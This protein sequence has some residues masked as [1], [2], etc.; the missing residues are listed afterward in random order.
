MRALIAERNPTVVV[1]NESKST[2]TSSLRG[3]WPGA[4]L[5]EIPAARR[6]WGNAPRAGVAIMIQPGVEYAAARI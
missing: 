3:V 6:E 4:S 2:N 5:E 1:I